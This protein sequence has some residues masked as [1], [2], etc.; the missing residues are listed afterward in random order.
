MAFTAEDHIGL[1]SVYMV[2]MNG[3]DFTTV[4]R[5]SIEASAAADQCQAAGNPAGGE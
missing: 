4:A 3:R 1:D 2:R 5:C